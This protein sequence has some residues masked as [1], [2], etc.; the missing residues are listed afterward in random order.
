MTPPMTPFQK[1]LLAM[2]DKKAGQLLG[3]R[4]RTAQAWRL[5]ERKPRP[6]RAREIVK[7]APVSLDDIYG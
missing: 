3:V 5:G 2:G 7:V 4:P 6:D 1:F